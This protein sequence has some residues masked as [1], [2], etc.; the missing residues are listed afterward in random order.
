MK[1]S[2]SN[3]IPVFA[4]HHIRVASVPDGVL[5]EVLLAEPRNPRRFRP[6]VSDV[7]STVRCGAP[8]GASRK[9]LAEWVEAPLETNDDLQPD[10]VALLESVGETF[11]RTMVL[12][13]RQ[14]DRD[15]REV[16]R[17]PRSGPKNDAAVSKDDVPEAPR[18]IGGG[19]GRSEVIVAADAR[20]EPLPR[21]HHVYR[22]GSP[23]HRRRGRDVP[24]AQLKDRATR[25]LGPRRVDGGRNLR[26]ADCLRRDRE[27]SLVP[28]LLAGTRHRTGAGQR[29]YH[30]EKE[31]CERLH[32]I[33][34]TAE[35][36]GDGT[37]RDGPAGPTPRGSRRQPGNFKPVFERQR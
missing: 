3:L 10:L 2:R 8:A 21:P 7:A 26:P 30:E 20:D 32:G 15:G 22:G 17:L 27:A 35:N 37:R 18:P 9:R 25:K 14:H 24:A 1:P 6:T 31:E 23:D 33:Q 29:Q 16:G 19:V 28:A 34:T 36:N 13:H 5:G 4:W 12:G 11:L